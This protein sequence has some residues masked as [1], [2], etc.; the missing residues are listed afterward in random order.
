[1][2]YISLFSGVGGLEA[3][4][5]GPLYLCDSDPDCAVVLSR[6]YPGCPNLPGC[7]SLTKNA[8]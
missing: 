7:S 2:K 8:C 6:L 4:D 1:M 5:G 3:S